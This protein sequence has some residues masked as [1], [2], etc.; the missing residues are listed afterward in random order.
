MSNFSQPAAMT[1]ERWR[2]LNEI[3]HAALDQP[4]SAREPYLAKACVGDLGLLLRVTEMLRNHERTTG[5]LDRT[6]WKG[7][8]PHLDRPRSFQPGQTVAGRYEI[9]RFIA[10]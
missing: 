2:Q 7:Q 1:P 5:I 9:V 6:P 3:F 8:P 4:E 10:K